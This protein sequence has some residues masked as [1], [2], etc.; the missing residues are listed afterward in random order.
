[1]QLN[2]SE[3][4]LYI[5]TLFI[6]IY[7]LLKKYPEKLSVMK[8]FLVPL[9]VVISLSTNAQFPPPGNFQFSYDYILIGNSGYC[10]GNWII[11]PAY[12]SHFTW[13]PPDTAST[14]ATLVHYNLYYVDNWNYDTIIFDSIADP[15]YDIQYGFMGYMWVTA[16]YSNPTGES[17]SSNIIYNETLPLSVKE[18]N[19]INNIEIS[20]DE[21]S[22]HLI[23]SNSKEIDKIRVYNIRGDEVMSVSLSSNRLNINRLS[24]GLYICEVLTKD[25]MLFRKKILK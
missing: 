24:R 21:Y 11:G 4:C 22:R 25:G 16:V 15:F 20:Y 19:L 7:K 18:N 2:T 1:M 23:F 6:Q 13:S 3:V 10:A 5:I 17:D 8:K 12:C 14:N 9:F